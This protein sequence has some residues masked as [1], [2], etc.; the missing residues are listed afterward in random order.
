MG[1]D[2]SFSCVSWS[3]QR[4]G[5]RNAERAKGNKRKSVFD[6]FCSTTNR[7]AFLTYLY[8]VPE[9]VKQPVIVVKHAVRQHFRRIYGQLAYNRGYENCSNA[10]VMMF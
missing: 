8:D 4:Q 1:V 9:G 6:L 5:S 3:V 10:E 2:N 7:Y